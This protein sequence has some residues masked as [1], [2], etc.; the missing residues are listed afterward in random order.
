MV[1]QNVR[2][3]NFNKQLC[4]DYNVAARSKP[5]NLWHGLTKLFE[6]HDFRIV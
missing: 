1:L 5:G 6:K 2:K 4:K 3:K